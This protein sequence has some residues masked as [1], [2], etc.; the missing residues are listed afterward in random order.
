MTP[1]K[2]SVQKKALKRKPYG[3]N[4]P[5]DEYYNNYDHDRDADKIRDDL[6]YLKKSQMAAHIVTT[7][8]ADMKPYHAAIAICTRYGIRG[9]YIDNPGDVMLFPNLAFS[10]TETRPPLYK[11]V[12]FVE[13]KKSRTCKRIIRNVEAD[14]AEIDE[15]RNRQQ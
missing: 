13:P 9:A 11:I 10:G 12:A 1:N 14:V 3:C 6:K 2:K 15:I 8:H 7:P 5:L 4:T